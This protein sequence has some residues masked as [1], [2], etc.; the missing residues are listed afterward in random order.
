MI[1][2]SLGTKEGI[3]AAIIMVIMNV[4]QD[5]TETE[6]LTVLNAGEPTSAIIFTKGSYFCPSYCKI[7]H[8]HRAHGVEYNCESDICHHF[9]VEPYDETS[10]L[11][12]K[13]VLE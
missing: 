4:Y 6:P 1:A 2:V 13:N 5:K 11:Q 3:I 7:S 9:I 10:A 8:P 12:V